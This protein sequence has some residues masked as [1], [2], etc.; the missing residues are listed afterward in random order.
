MKQ[1]YFRNKLKPIHLIVL[2]G[3]FLFPFFTKIVLCLKYGYLYDGDSVGV[4]LLIIISHF[5]VLDYVL[6]SISIFAP[7]TAFIIAIILFT[8][9]KK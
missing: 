3:A 1:L 4:D 5:T 8:Q 6:I 7:M 2:S 9:E